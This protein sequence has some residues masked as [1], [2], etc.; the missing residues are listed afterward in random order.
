MQTITLQHTVFAVHTGERSL[1]YFPARS[2]A[3]AIAD[4]A[5]AFDTVE[6]LLEAEPEDHRT[7]QLHREVRKHAEVAASIEIAWR[8]HDRWPAYVERVTRERQRHTDAVTRILTH[9]QGETS[10]RRRTRPTASCLKSQVAQHTSRQRSRNMSKSSPAT[11]TAPSADPSVNLRPYRLEGSDRIEQ[12]DAG[13]AQIRNMSRTDGRKWQLVTDGSAVGKPKVEAKPQPKVAAPAPV[14]PPAAKSKPA[15]KPTKA[16]AKTPAKAS[17]P[18]K[19]AKAKPEKAA[20]VSHVKGW[21]GHSAYSLA[22]YLG[23]K[24]WKPAEAQR[25]YEKL[26]INMSPLALRSGLYAGKAGKLFIPELTA[27]H[28][29]E[30]ESVR[31]ATTAA[32]A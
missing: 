21:N 12:L 6:D 22:R 11:V 16:K 28:A 2:A 31:K 8:P 20:H 23:S 13:Q 4:A 26:G 1:G 29:K 10:A 17:K 7:A 25:V 15:A 19:V 9:E 3:S 24:G 32:A 5:E 27:A 14:T 30:L 18:A